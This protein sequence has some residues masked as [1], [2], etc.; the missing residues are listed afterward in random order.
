M[1][2]T[3]QKLSLLWICIALLV[4]SYAWAKNGAILANLSPD[5]GGSPMASPVFDS[6]GNLY[7]S[8]YG[9]A[10]GHGSV[11]E[12]SPTAAGQWNISDIHAFAGS[13]AD[14]AHPESSL[15]FDAAGNLYGTTLYGGT[16][17]VG[18]VF[19]LAP[20]GNGQWTESIIYNFGTNASLPTSGV[21]FD[22]AGNLYGEASLGVGAG[23]GVVYE[24]SPA[25]NGTWTETIVYNFSAPGDGVF[26]FG[27]LA[28]DDSGNLY[29]TT[30]NGGSV[31]KGTVFRLSPGAGG[32]TETILYDF[33]ADRDGNGPSGVT[34]DSAGNLFGT[35]YR[36]GMHKGGRLFE[37]SPASGL[38]QETVIHDFGWAIDGA[39]PRGRPVIDS[40]GNLYGATYGGGTSGEGIVYELSPITGGGW[41]EKILHQFPYDAFD[42]FFPESGPILDSLGNLYGV[43]PD[44]GKLGVGVAYRITPN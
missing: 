1:R 42:G 38:W 11:V 39:C 26:P 9:Y 24:L 7:F 19:K 20:A 27:D 2:T 44:G 32:W 14:G 36:G 10:T 6:A 37:L 16:W 25:G 23:E 33:S 29:G 34:L 35:T 43:T 22:S 31:D 18:T 40:A 17:R 3:S 21:V 5:N 30:G 13:P 12:A 8:A 28:I 4:S 41:K 15:V